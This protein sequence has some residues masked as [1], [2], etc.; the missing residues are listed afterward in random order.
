MAKVE[1]ISSCII[2]M[3]G[4]NAN[5]I[6]RLDLTPCDL[7]LLPLDPIQKGI[8]FH[9]PLSKLNLIDHLKTS[10]SRTL[11]FFPPLA[12][13]LATTAHAH[14]TFSLFLDCNNAGVE[15]VHAV[16][17]ATSVA[18]ILEPK[19]IP[20]IVASFFPHNGLSNWDVVSKPVLVAQVTELVDGVFIGC[21]ANHAVIDGV[22][23]WHF[24]N[25]WSE[26]SRGSDT[27]S[28][29][30]VFKPWFPSNVPDDKRPL[31]L[32]WLEQ[33]PPLSSVPPPRLERVFHFSKQTLSKLKAR[34]NSEAATDKI[35]SL[36]ALSAHLWRSI[37]RCRYSGMSLDDGREAPFGII[38]GLRTRIP[39]PEGYFGNALVSAKMTMSAAELVQKGVGHAAVRINELVAQHTKEKVIKVIEDW[40]VSPTLLRRGNYAFVMASSP[41]HNVYGNDFGWGKPIAVRS[42]PA[43]KIDGK[44]TL[45]PAA[46]AGGIDVEVCLAPETLRAIEDD[47]QFMEVFTV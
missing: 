45:F 1:A 24:F 6:S 18:D 7:Q 27:I 36:Q 42:G 33:D 44:M 30:P 9:N 32:P 3:A 26:I 19:W 25:S 8:L 17:A 22:S 15:F 47:A 5:P 2:R 29:T 46:E 34:A 38:V 37:S 13:R 43:T 11:D 14:A 10:L 12:G 4:N 21:T 39:L 40:V 23:F 28:K 20:E 41:R 31:R 16:A 35:S